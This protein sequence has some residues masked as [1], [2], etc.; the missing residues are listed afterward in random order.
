M[1][2]FWWWIAIGFAAIITF[3]T[4]LHAEC[5]SQSAARRA[6]PS[7][8]LSYGR[9]DGHK[10]A[11]CWYADSASLGLTATSQRGR[12][13]VPGT[14]AQ[15]AGR[16]TLDLTKQEKVLSTPEVIL[17][18]SIERW[19]ASVLKERDSSASF[20]ARFEFAYGQ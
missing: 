16:P 12:S 7:V 13:R 11:R 17:P 18:P 10:G 9:V 14:Q 4:C 1:R 8:H 2:S 15:L 5:L 20:A 19:I 3:S 6:N